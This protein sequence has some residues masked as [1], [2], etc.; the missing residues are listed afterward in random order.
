ME[1]G[2]GGRLEWHLVEVRIQQEMEDPEP[3]QDVEGTVDSYSLGQHTLRNGI[4]DTANDSLMLVILRNYSPRMKL[5]RNCHLPPYGLIISYL[6][7]KPS[8]LYQEVTAV[9]ELRSDDVPH[10]N[11]T[12]YF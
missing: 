1:R 4:Q 5:S 12:G 9:L 6:A 7:S 3:E 11:F 2:G 8:L 10:K